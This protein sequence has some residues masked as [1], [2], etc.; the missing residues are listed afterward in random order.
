MEADGEY[1]RSFIH[2]PFIQQALWKTL[3]AG[4]NGP[5]ARTTKMSRRIESSPRGST[6]LWGTRTQI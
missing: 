6:L 1:L 2:S 5:E 3:S 4:D